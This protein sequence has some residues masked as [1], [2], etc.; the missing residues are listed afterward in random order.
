MISQLAHEIN[1]S[2]TLALAQK[3]RPLK[4]NGGDIVDL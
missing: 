3:T 1:D 4:A 2:P